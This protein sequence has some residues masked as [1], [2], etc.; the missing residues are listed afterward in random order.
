M[1]KFKFITVNA[2]KKHMSYMERNTIKEFHIEKIK[3]DYIM[4]KN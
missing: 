2:Y 3:I 4:N 1:F